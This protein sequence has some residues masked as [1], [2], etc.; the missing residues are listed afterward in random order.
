MEYM[1][2]G[3]DELSGDTDSVA[4]TV[5]APRLA[6]IVADC[7]DVTI[8]V[9]IAKVALV[10]PAATVIDAGTRALGLLLKTAI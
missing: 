6:V 5:D 2:G 10:W 4:V 7:T 8:V 9:V 1:L 3:P